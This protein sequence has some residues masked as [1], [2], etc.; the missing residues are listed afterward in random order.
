MT[1]VLYCTHGHVP[2]NKK[3]VTSC[4]ITFVQLPLEVKHVYFIVLL[5]FSSC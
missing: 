3:E 5:D 1:D 2:K 4:N